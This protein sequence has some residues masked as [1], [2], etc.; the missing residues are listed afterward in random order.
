MTHTAIAKNRGVILQMA[1]GKC[2]NK[3]MKTIFSP[4]FFL[5]FS[6]YGSRRLFWYIII[7][8]A[9]LHMEKL[10]FEDASSGCYFW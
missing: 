2:E 7:E 9:S 3:P 6:F 5:S 8:I 10:T 1:V 4:L